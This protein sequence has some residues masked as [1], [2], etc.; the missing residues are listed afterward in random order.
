MRAD[1]W[2]ARNDENGWPDNGVSLKC[3]E[4]RAPG[5]DCDLTLQ[6]SRHP[7]S[8]LPMIIPH[9]A[10][11]HPR[12]L[13]AS[14]RRSYPQRNAQSKPGV[15]C[16][17]V[18]LLVRPLTTA[19]ALV[20]FVEVHAAHGYLFH[21]FLSPLSNTRTDQYGGQ[22]LENRLR[23]PLKVI[24]S[25]REAWGTEKPLFV[26]LSATDWAEGDERGSDGK[27]RYWGVEQTKIFVEESQKLGV[28]LIDVSSGG[29]WAKQKI[30]LGPGYQVCIPPTRH[31]AAP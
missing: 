17:I 8:H 30:T 3:S 5:P 28:D 20:D 29:L 19:F 4:T 24:K 23:F 22:P 6:S 12:T 10:R 18:V 15:R 1:R 26:R 14:R 13:S 31:L 11:R 16:S 27:W 21:E 2:V 25:V 9:H 7:K